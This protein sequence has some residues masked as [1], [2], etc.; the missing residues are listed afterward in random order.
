MR[1]TDLETACPQ[2]KFPWRKHTEINSY[3]QFI[4]KCPEIPPEKIDFAL[5]VVMA[6]VGLFCLYLGGQ[7]IRVTFF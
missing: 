6:L 3:G 7:I 5:W 4:Y 2:C 1:I